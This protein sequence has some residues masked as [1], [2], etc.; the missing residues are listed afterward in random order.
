M[1]NTINRGA[2]GDEGVFALLWSAIK[3]RFACDKVLIVITI[4]FFCI[5]LLAVYTASSQ[6]GFKDGTIDQEFSR[7]I[8][9]IG[10]ALIALIV[11]YIPTPKFYRIFTVLAYAVSLLMTFAPYF[12]DS[13]TNDEHRWLDLGFISLQPSEFLKIG[14]VM[15]LS[16][17]ISSRYHKIHE[18]HLMPTTFNIKRWWSDPKER[19]IILREVLPLVMPIALACIAIV[20]SHTSSAIHVFIVSMGMLA[21]ARIRAKELFKLTIVAGVLGIAL[22]FLIGRGDTVISRVKD[23]IGIEQQVNDSESIKKSKN[24]EGDGYFSAL[25]IH[26]GKMFGVGPGRSMMRAKLTHPESDY[27]FAVIAEEFGIAPSF[28]IILLYFWLFSRAKRIFKKCEWVFAGLLAVGLALIIVSQGFIHIGV[29]LGI[30]P[31]TGQNLPFIT[32]GRS[33]MVCAAI[34]MG[35]ILSISCHTNRGEVHPPSKQQKQNLKQ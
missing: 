20:P 34:A 22:V 6:L 7:H 35:M 23:W 5:S 11:A 28:I 2:S 27:L 33:G 19:N 32:H 13:A 25:A 17:Q 31:E 21:L 1:N 10:M 9:T 29:A 26:N 14:T 30:L 12:M 15:L 16:A 4:L 24:E 3:Q 18:L 8:T